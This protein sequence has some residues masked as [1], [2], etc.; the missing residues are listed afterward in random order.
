MP[1]LERS[2]APHRLRDALSLPYNRKM[3]AILGLLMVVDLWLVNAAHLTG[4]R[5]YLDIWPEILLLI[6]CTAY[7]VYR[8]LPRIVVSCELMFW[9]ALL[10]N[11]LSLLIQIAGR[12]PVPL[13]DRKLFAIDS[14]LHFSTVYFVHLAAHAP[15]LHLIFLLSYPVIWPL[16]L[17]TILF[18][19]PLGHPEQAR[20]FV[21]AATIA[22]ILT[23]ILFAACPAA[24][25]WMVEG[26]PPAHDQ[27]G[28]TAYLE[29][30]K[31]SGPVA[32]DIPDSAIVSFPS[33]HVALAL[34]TGWA[35]HAFRRLRAPVWIL[36]VLI[37]VSTVPTGWHYGTDVL[38][39]AGVA[40]ASIAAA[41][42]LHRV[43]AG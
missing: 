34:I 3:A 31:S 29:R 15:V 39:G 28:I 20:R 17:A 26:F 10:N 8:P 13:L 7:A 37:C 40:V 5:V 41:S 18:L 36:V 24:G 43:E 27:A 30:L 2:S 4:A 32:L 19:P 42:R 22:T 16:V 25:P 11:A 6:L 1:V 14:A 33:F 9:A 38:A 23:A 35:L 21:L 12:S